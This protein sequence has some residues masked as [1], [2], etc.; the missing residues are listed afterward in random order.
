[1]RCRPRPCAGGAARR[2]QGRAPRCVTGNAQGRRRDR[3]GPGEYSP[4]CYLAAGAAGVA[5]VAGAAAA[6]GAAATCL[7][8]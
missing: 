7:T 5:G 4:G 1:M 3:D 8:L 2:G 6:A